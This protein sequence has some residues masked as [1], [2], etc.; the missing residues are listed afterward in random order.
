MGRDLARTSSGG[1]PLQMLE[2]PLLA[3]L[4]TLTY[5]SPNLGRV[6]RKPKYPKTNKTITTAPTSQM[7]LFMIP[8]LCLG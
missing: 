5:R 4:C 7:I 2:P 3:S 6:Q 1:A 8:F